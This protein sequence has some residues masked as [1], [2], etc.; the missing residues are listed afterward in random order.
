MEQNT[1][2]NVNK[3]YTD[4]VT[5]KFLPGNPGGGRPKNTQSFSTLYKK[6]IENIAKAKGVT[7]E[8]FEVQ[9]VQ[10]AIA[11]GFNG[12]RSFYADTMDRVHG[13]APQSIDHTTDGKSFDTIN[14]NVVTQPTS[15]QDT[16]EEPSEQD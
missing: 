3:S 6:A 1:E 14:I 7:P 16:G 13:K 2:E 5:G 8:D 12:D 15:E 4:P 11:K 9:L 10:Q